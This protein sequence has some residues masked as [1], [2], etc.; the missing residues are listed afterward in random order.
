MRQSEEGTGS[1]IAT[2]AAAALGNAADPDLV[3][4]IRQEIRLDDRS[5]LTTYGDQAQRG[6]AAFADTILRDTLN[7]DSGPVGALLSDLIAKVNS[8]DPASLGKAGLLER[9]WG[10]AKVRVLRFRE[11]FSSLAAQVDRIALDL[12]RRSDALRRDIAMLDGLFERN[13]AQMRELEAYIVAGTQIIEEVRR[14]RLPALEAQARAAGEGVEGQLAAQAAADLAQSVER[15]E[16]KVHDLKLSRMIALQTMPQ[17]R[18]VQNGDAALVEKL[19][20]S[21]AT[22]IPTWK[23]G[24]TIALALHRQ[25]AALKLQRE[26]SDTTNA[27]LKANAER[28]RQG[29]AGIEREVQR[30]IVDIETLSHVNRQFVETVNE[31]LAIQRDGQAK[32]RAAEA[33]LT[34]IEDELKRTLLG[35]PA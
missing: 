28:L 18:L 2:S 10:G 17:I 15:L 16:R 33:E 13:L 19:Q 12:E 34:R 27:L 8:L 3:Q 22:T 1:A 25:D 26:V 35:Q 32:R 21:I 4:R 29:T 5:A 20:S 7:K 11:R 6:V 9:L 24:M 31:V 14:E 30:G 23:N